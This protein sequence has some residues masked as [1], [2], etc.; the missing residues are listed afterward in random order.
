MFLGEVSFSDKRHIC[1][2]IFP[3]SHCSCFVLDHVA[4]SWTHLWGKSVTCCLWHHWAVKQIPPTSR[5]LIIFSLSEEMHTHTH[6]T[7]MCL[8]QCWSGYLLLPPAVFLTA[9]AKSIVFDLDISHIHQLLFTHYSLHSS[10][11]DLL[12]AY[13]TCT[14]PLFIA[15]LHIL[16]P[17]SGIFFLFPVKKTK[18]SWVILKILLELY[19]DSLIEQHA[20]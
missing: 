16:F 3:F 15:A 9:I 18:F 5:I 10:L 11:T 8:T 2:E 19:N 14:F 13:S 20:I 17:L 7:L 12:S 4:W 1:Q 6:T